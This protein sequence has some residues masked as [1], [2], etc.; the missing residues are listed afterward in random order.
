MASSSSKKWWQSKTVIGGVL[1]TLLGAFLGLQ[2]LGFFDTVVLPGALVVGLGA[3]FGFTV[4]AGR[5]V[6][7]DKISPGAGTLSR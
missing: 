6:A 4:V 3:V 7:T 5:V 2:Q 1:Q